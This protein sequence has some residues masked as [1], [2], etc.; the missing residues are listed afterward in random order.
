MKNYFWADFHR[1]MTK[2]SRIFLVILLA[3]AEGMFILKD[4]LSDRN[5][6]EATNNIG[7]LDLLY[8][9][10]IMLANIWISFGDD[11][12]A[13]SM[14]A[15]LG[16]GIKRYQIVITKWMTMIGISVLD[17]A[18]LMAV[19]VIPLMAA[20]RLAGG[21]VMEQMIF[22]QISNILLIIVM[23][24]LT[25][26]VLFQTQKAIL[27]VL[28]YTYLTLGITDFMISMAV[29][30]K[31]VQKFQLWNIGAADQVSIFLS[32]LLIG[33]FDIR[34]FLMIVC[35]FAFGL[36]AAIYLFQKKELDF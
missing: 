18:F 9:N 10:G 8:I 22:R 20:G 29:A 31:I 2:K 24:P 4:I 27:G 3:A 32:K 16:I 35:Y 25:M 14:Q 17:I 1:I 6:I 13:K 26:T 33:Q 11:I 36:G 21:F 15:A 19:Q 23:M 12:R 5:I 30:N 34:N 7:R 28:A